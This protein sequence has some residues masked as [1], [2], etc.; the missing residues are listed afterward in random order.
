MLR[1]GPKPETPSSELKGRRRSILGG[2]GALLARPGLQE[3]LDGLRRPPPLPRVRTGVLRGG[4]GLQEAGEMAAVASNADYGAE[5][6]A[7]AA[8]ATQRAQE[9]A[10]AASREDW[11]A[12]GRERAREAEQRARGL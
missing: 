10:A 12:E 9:T 7:R 1:V 3:L 4:L 11:G 2:T 5:G 6:R 8:E